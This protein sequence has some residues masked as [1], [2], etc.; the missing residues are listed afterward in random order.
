MHITFNRT[1]F[2]KFFDR[3]DRRPQF[4]NDVISKFKESDVYATWSH[5][6]RI[7]RRGVYVRYAENVVSECICFVNNE[8]WPDLKPLARLDVLRDMLGRVTSTQQGEFFIVEEF[9]QH[10][11]LAHSLPVLTFKGE[12]NQMVTIEDWVQALKS[13]GIVYASG[14]ADQNEFCRWED[15]LDRC[16]STDFEH[17]SIDRKDP[18]DRN[19]GSHRYKLVIGEL[20][21]VDLFSG[22]CLLVSSSK[23]SWVHRFLE[24]FVHYIP[25]MMDDVR[26]TLDWCW[27]N[28]KQIRQ[29]AERLLLWTRT[30]CTQNEMIIHLNRLFGE[31][32]NCVTYSPHRYGDFVRENVAPINFCIPWV[33]YKSR[34]SSDV[35]VDA[36]WAVHCFFQAAVKIFYLQWHHGVL[37]R[38]HFSVQKHDKSSIVINE[39]YD[40][41]FNESPYCVMVDLDPA[42]T[43][44]IDENGLTNHPFVLNQNNIVD[45]CDV[46][47]QH[48]QLRPMCARLKSHALANGWRSTYDFLFQHFYQPHQ[49]YVRYLPTPFLALSS[50][51]VNTNLLPI[52]FD[53]NT[54]KLIIYRHYQ[55]LKRVLSKFHERY[56]RE[57][58]R[59]VQPTLVQYSLWLEP[60]TLDDWMRMLYEG[61]SV[62]IPDSNDSVYQRLVLELEAV[63]SKADWLTYQTMFK[64]LMQLDKVSYSINY[65][66]LKT[67]KTF[68]EQ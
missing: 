43:Y 61:V 9:E 1:D 40:H 34:K 64:S 14:L 38:V 58:L 35:S 24:P 47:D 21:G 26:N 55:I 66:L 33:T 27:S 37:G 16:L 49:R 29:I 15:K 20:C 68:T 25:L 11:E 46:F 48:E 57:C 65:A 13:E 18:K 62:Q 2:L 32:D 52:Q 45:V 3:R 23:K 39:L 6:Y 22:S 28:P 56:Y 12:S 60:M 4:G 50:T 31:H 30:H 19:G 42:H 67:I 54:N 59:K 63:W 17:E 5:L 51:S 44:Y 7:C 10:Q 53:L 41:V 8:E 36:Q